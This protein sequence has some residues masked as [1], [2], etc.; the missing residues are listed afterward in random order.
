V[1]CDAFDGEALEGGED[2]EVEGDKET[3][4]DVVM[5]DDE[6][7]K[8]KVVRN[9]EILKSDKVAAT[10]NTK[11]LTAGGVT[12]ATTGGIKVM[13]LVE[14]LVNVVIFDV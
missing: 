14:L 3:M 5:I 8:Y 1:V 6:P 7:S 12:V 13:R 10:G 4:D 9:V 2:N 11:V